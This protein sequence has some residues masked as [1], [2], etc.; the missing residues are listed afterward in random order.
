[1]SGFLFLIYITSI[2]SFGNPFLSPIAPFYPKMQNNAI[3]LTNK[4]KFER[5]NALSADKNTSKVGENK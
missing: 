1:M 4:R 5:R 2:K 3:F